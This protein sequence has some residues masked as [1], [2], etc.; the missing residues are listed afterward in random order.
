[1]QGLCDEIGPA[2]SAEHTQRSKQRARLATAGVGAADGE[3]PVAAHNQ[4]IDMR[5]E[6]LFERI[7]AVQASAPPAS[8]PMRCS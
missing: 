3:R 5:F 1:M 7:S 2:L 6:P 4:R 8:K